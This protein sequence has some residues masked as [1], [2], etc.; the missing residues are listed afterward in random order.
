MTSYLENAL[1][2]TVFIEDCLEEAF[3]ESC[4]VGNLIYSLNTS[5]STLDTIYSTVT[6]TF[7]MVQQDEV[8]NDFYY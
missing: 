1:T 8:F 3:Q 4:V 7:A 2:L 5:A 6:D